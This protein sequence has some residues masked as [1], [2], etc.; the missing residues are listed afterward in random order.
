MRRIVRFSAVALLVSLML[1]AA[2][3]QAPRPRF[4]PALLGSGPDSLINRINAA[5]LMKKGQK[6]GTIMFASLAA[7]DGRL[8]GSRLYRAKP[9]S[10]ILREELQRQLEQ[11]KVAPAIYNH[12]PVDVLFYGTV[13]FRIVNEKPRLRIFLH[14]DPAELIKESDFIGPQPVFGADSKFA[15]L[16]YP[17]AEQEAAVTGIVDLGIRVDGDGNLQQLKVIAEEPASLGFGAAALADFDG[18][19]FVPAFRD[20]DPDTSNTVIP[21]C[22]EKKD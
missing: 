9:G 18:T 12:Q 20:G 19:K 6:D 11:T 21:L 8:V 15:G 13:V 5:E 7:K 16:R 14:Q 2:D 3:A 22:Y 1:G 4:R 17:P 10:D